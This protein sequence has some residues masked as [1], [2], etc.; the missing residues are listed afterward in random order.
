MGGSHGWLSQRLSALAQR[1]QPVDFDA[2][3]HQ[4]LCFA[5]SED[6]EG[7]LGLCPGLLAMGSVL[8]GHISFLSPDISQ[9]EW[10]DLTARSP[11]IGEISPG[12]FQMQQE[13]NV[14][15]VQ[16]VFWLLIPPGNWLYC[17][18]FLTKLS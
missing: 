3:Q 1:Q 11:A 17:S 5:S 7:P 10:R 12:L 15:R 14:T 9:P 13:V 4:L 16:L 18:F 8:G 6:T 2:D